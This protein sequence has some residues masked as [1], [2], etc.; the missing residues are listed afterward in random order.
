[1]EYIDHIVRGSHYI[2]LGFLSKIRLLLRKGLEPW[3]ILLMILLIL[4]RV[5]L[6]VPFK[7]KRFPLYSTYSWAGVF[8]SAPIRQE[9]IL[10]LIWYHI[11]LLLPLWVLEIVFIEHFVKV[12]N[13]L[14]RLVAFLFPHQ[15]TLVKQLVSLH[16]VKVRVLDSMMA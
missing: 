2:L 13:L 9:G 6:V 10:R 16:N 5:V 8:S 7:L 3:A 12:H 4:L 1:M 14:M 11:L 15:S